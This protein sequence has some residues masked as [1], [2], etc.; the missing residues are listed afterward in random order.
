MI[1]ANSRSLCN[2]C[3]KRVLSHSYHL[4]CDLCRCNVHINCLPFIDKTNDLYVKRNTNSWFCTLCMMNIL[5]FNHF[6]DDQQFILAVLEDKINK[7]SVTFSELLNQ[8]KLFVPFELNNDDTSPML[9]LDPDLQYYKSVSNLN[10][11][12]CNYHIED[13][14]NDKVSNLNITSNCLSFIHTNIRSIPKNLGKFEAYLES[15]SHT[16]SVIGL[17]ESW[18]SDHS[19]NHYAMIGYAGEHRYRKNRSGGGVSLFIKE[20]IEYQVRDDLC[21]MDGNIETIFIE[22]DKDL[23]N[24]DKNCI[25]GVVYRPPDT[26]VNQFNEKIGEILSNIKTEKKLAY[27]LGDFNLNLLSIDKHKDTQDFI[28]AMYSF[29]MF[30]CITKPTRVT[31]RSATLIDN[32]YINDVLNENAVS[33]ILYTDISDHFPVFYIDYSCIVPSEPQIIKKRIYS[34]KNIDAFS[35]SIERHDWTDV[36]K[37]NDPQIAYTCFHNDFHSIYEK[38][39]PLRSFKEGYKTRKS[40]LTEG[41]KTS[42]KI[43]NRMYKRQKRTQNPEHEKEYRK[44]KN[45]LNALLSKAEREHYHTLLQKNLN[46]MKK[47]WTILKDAINRKKNSSSCSRF[48]VNNSITTDRK[49]IVD[50]F[51]A[52]FTDIGPN[53]A[54][55]IPN[56]SKRPE[57]F[58]A[59]NLVNSIYI[60]PVVEDEVKNIIKNLKESSAGWDSISSRIVKNTYEFFL[61]PL[62]Y[63]M[64]LSLIKGVVPSE[65][66]IAKVIPLFKSGD[67]TKFSNYRPVSVLPVFSKILERLM[68]VR[69][70]SFINK[71]KLLYKFQFGFRA[72][73]SPQL[74]LIYLIDKISNALENGEFVLGVFLDFS[75]AFDTVNHEILFTKLN[76]YGV[77]DNALEWFK[78]YLSNREQFVSY[79]GFESTKRV[80]KCGVPQGSILGPLLF[81]IYINDLALVSDK[82]FA[83]LFADDSNMFL[84]GQNPDSLIDSMNTELEKVIDWL[85]VNKLSLNLKKTHFIIFR[86]RKE[87]ILLTNVLKINDIVIEMTEN[88]KF[89]GVL[90]DQHLNFQSHIAY[91]KGKISR[92]LGILYKAKK[93]FDHTIL[94]MLYN[95]FINPLFAYCICVWGNAP[96]SYL[97]PLIKLQKRAIRVIAGVKKLA[98]TAPLF[99]KL[100]VMN[101]KN[102]YIYNTILIMYKFHQDKLPSIFHSMFIRNNE[103]HSYNTRRHAQLHVLQKTSTRSALN[104]K[105]CGVRIYNFF[106][107]RLNFDAK[108]S[109]FKKNVKK[110]ILENDTSS[111]VT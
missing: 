81:L 61:S 17:S 21:H 32:V 109:S 12:T 79:D 64:N 18:L 30:P 56:N 37:S 24:K 33:G 28:D 108:L 14:F 53:L 85:N 104:F 90:I 52:F 63:I 91:I 4:Q 110:Y 84:T 36:L 98:H 100:K 3:N 47:S 77:R 1:M 31:S 38:C 16:F 29:S 58:L 35:K 55:K 75:K 65:L 60:K 59:N 68:Y 34:Q 80:I 57:V 19:V 11:Q 72:D 103:I 41:I 9:D 48:M 94:L 22:I 39:F 27:L 78:S 2:L 71:N 51:N 82:L 88:T 6:E 107:S 74:A 99:K 83:L 105:F 10:M 5:P 7:S 15:L 50:G 86:R 73:H 76:H 43:K 13:S 96:E 93:L 89:L 45:K 44:Y 92:T 8:N 70:L 42:I 87:R 97:D 111:L 102:I 46:N 95:S 49:T 54:S 40:W 20:S 69:L 62:T 23:I 25:V 106:E 66:K 101:L 67:P 26:N